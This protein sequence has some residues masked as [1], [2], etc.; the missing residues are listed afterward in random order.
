MAKN[1]HCQK[2]FIAYGPYDMGHNHANLMLAI[3]NGQ[4]DEQNS[5]YSR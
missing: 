1:I 2:I 4:A 5:Y 3:L